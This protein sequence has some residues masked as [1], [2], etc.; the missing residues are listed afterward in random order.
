MA[1]IMD[2]VDYIYGEMFTVCY[3]EGLVLLGTEDGGG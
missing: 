1:P 3:Y 2:I